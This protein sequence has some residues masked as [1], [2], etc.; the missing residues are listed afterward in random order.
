MANAF[1]IDF[2]APAAVTNL[3]AIP[4]TLLRAPEPDAVFIS[5]LPVATAPENLI[6][7]ELWMTDGTTGPDGLAIWTKL[8][9]WTDPSVRTYLYPYPA[10]N[11]NVLYQ[12]NQVVRSGASTLTG[13]WG[14]DAA[15]VTL[16][17]ISLVS[18]LAPQTRR[19]AIM[20]WPTERE[21][22]VQEQDWHVPAGGTNYIELPGSLRGRE[23]NMSGQLFDRP[24]G[25]TAE[26]TMQ[27]FRNLFDTKDIFCARDPRGG[28][29]FARFLGN[30]T[31][32]YGK[33]GVRHELDFNIRRVAFVEGVA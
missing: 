16:N 27:D 15:Q 24:D 22:L 25:V 28:K 12:I 33:G 21:T 5:W 31:S 2:T 30:P 1:T 23:V 6:R 20:A 9:W 14:N 11:K 26:Q 32:N 8:G 19:V 10:S 7:Q 3:T 29:W 18:V 17:H 13:L 4:Y